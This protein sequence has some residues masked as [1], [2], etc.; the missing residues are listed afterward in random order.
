MALEECYFSIQIQLLLLIRLEWQVLCLWPDFFLPIRLLKSRKCE[1]TIPVK[2]M[3]IWPSLCGN[4]F[5]QLTLPENPFLI[6]FTTMQ[7]L[8]C[9]LLRVSTFFT[10]LW[11]K[12]IQPKEKKTILLHHKSYQHVN[13]N[14]FSLSGNQ[15][16]RQFYRCVQSR[17][18][19]REFEGCCVNTFEAFQQRE[20]R[21]RNFR[22]SVSTEPWAVWPQLSQVSYT[23]I[24]W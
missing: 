2:D 18:D 3:S 6:S 12:I 23:V 5:L 9:T 8:I 19:A 21:W 22:H 15:L 13:M 4:D 20:Q 11:S 7:L 10:L 16:L 1:N 24:L 14:F 17:S